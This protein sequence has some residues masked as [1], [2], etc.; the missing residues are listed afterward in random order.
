M[1]E[2]DYIA[3][4]VKE[5]HPGLLGV[6]FALWKAGKVAIETIRSFRSPLESIDWKSIAVS[7]EK[8]EEAIEKEEAADES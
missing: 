6:D 1:T 7:V 3:E 2:N 4:Y 8:A 5:K